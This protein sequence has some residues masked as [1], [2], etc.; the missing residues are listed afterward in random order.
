MT[1]SL[2]LLA[3]GILALTVLPFAA[4][5]S[6]GSYHYPDGHSEYDVTFVTYY[7]GGEPKTTINVVTHVY[8]NTTV[9]PYQIP[10]LPEGM[11]GWY[12]YYDEWDPSAPVTKDM[13]I[14]AAPH[15]T[16]WGPEKDPEPEPEPSVH[17]EIG[18]VTIGT[19]VGIVIALVASVLF[20][21]SKV[22]N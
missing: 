19:G 4:D 12:Y 16:P 22:E 21:A 13:E 14:M 5:D 2:P 3:V 7:Y 9:D 15:G 20:I 8:E 11:T 1:I 6:E 17:K 18:W 10:P